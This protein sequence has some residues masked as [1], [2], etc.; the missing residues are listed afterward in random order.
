MFCVETLI[1][2]YWEK[3]TENEQLFDGMIDVKLFDG[4]EGLKSQLMRTW[5]QILYV[6]GFLCNNLT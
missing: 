5:Y 3:K 6:K 4:V 2:D 1:L